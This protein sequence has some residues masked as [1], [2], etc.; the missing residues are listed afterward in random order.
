MPSS[1]IMMRLRVLLMGN[2]VNATETWMALNR[3]RVGIRMGHPLI[4]FT[5]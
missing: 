4:A 2:N 1:V 5:L 3:T